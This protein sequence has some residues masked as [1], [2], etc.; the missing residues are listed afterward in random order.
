MLITDGSALVTPGTVPLCGPMSARG[1]RSADVERGAR[2]ERLYG[3]PPEI[4]EKEKRMLWLIIG[5]VLLIIAIAGGVI[6]HPILFV[7]AILALVAFFAGRG[8]TAP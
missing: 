3:A 1:R 5:V 6:V 7:I 4:A 2:S 8:R